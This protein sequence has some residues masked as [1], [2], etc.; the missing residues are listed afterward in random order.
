MASQ[1]G[2]GKP[3]TARCQC[4]NVSFSTPAARPI[5]LYHCHC[6]ECQ[7][8]SA[9]AYGT[10]AMYPAEALFPLSPDLAS[11]LK[12]FTRPTTSGG[13]MD[14]Y[15]CPDCGTR[16]FH[17]VTEKDGTP[18]PTVSLKGG[19]IE[20]LDWEGGKHIYMRSAVIKIPEDW[21]QYD[22]VAPSMQRE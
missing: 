18:R 10:S 12:V 1:Q 13:K 3:L 22:T 19:C 21:E 11:K 6:T 15:F 14:C 17:R 16:I 5:G 8:Q 9:S 4:G 2:E 20:G 7:K